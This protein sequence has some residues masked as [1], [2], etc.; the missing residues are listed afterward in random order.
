[1]TNTGLTHRLARIDDL[2]ALRDL[3]NAA[4]SELQKPFL[5]KSQIASSR[6]IMGL[7]TQLVEDGT[8]FIVEARW[9]WRLEPPCHALRRRS[10]AGS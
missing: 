10:I 7:D 8:Y 1:M 4:I 2:D 6:T 3:I 9:L 5:D